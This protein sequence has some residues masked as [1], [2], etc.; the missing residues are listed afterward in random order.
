[1]SPSL[2]TRAS[3]DADAFG[4]FLSQVG[5]HPL[6]DARSERA[7]AA[8]IADARAD[9]ARALALIPGVVDGI[10]DELARRLAAGER[11]QEL[12]D[13]LLADEG[14]EAQ[15]PNSAQA[16]DALRAVERLVSLAQSVRGDALAAEQRVLAREWLLRQ[17]TAIRWRQAALRSFVEP[18]RNA[19]DVVAETERTLRQLCRYAGGVAPG[20]LEQLPPGALDQQALMALA[21]AGRLSPGSAA[22]LE[23]QLQAAWGEQRAAALPLGLAP[24]ELMERGAALDRAEARVFDLNGRMVRANLRLVISIARNYLGR[25]V[26]LADLVQDGNIGLLRAVDRFDHRRGFR[27]STY[28]TWWIRQAVTRAI[29]EQGRA[30]RLPQLLVEM[31]M[32]VRA[33][34]SR[35]LALHGREPGIADLLAMDLG[36]EDR[37]R[38][39]FELAPEPVSLDAP[40]AADTSDTLASRVALPDGP[41]PEGDTDTLLLE[42]A[43][44]QMLA[45]LDTRAAEVLR[46]R[47]G[48]GT[49]RD[50]TLV[51]IGA[52]LGMSRERVRQI[53]REAL[54]ELRRRAPQ[55]RDLL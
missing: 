17:F 37:V 9:W 34:T 3:V 7:L 28:A 33:V 6:L 10:A 13:G 44:A 53:E 40:V 15:A 52:A 1:M 29:A 51:E 27:F 18:F 41:A 11:W 21:A 31:V 38:Q 20:H 16:D 4:H 36:P 54:E 12:V 8:E 50:H 49:G 45:L 19:Y 48:V 5:R 23:Q 25:G 46:M 24:R 14:A 2:R 42:R 35:H 47:F 43:A 32:K 30:I 55:V 39:A 22:A 26:D